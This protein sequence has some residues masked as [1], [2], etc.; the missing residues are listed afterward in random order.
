MFFGSY[1]AMVI[2]VI[3]AVT[4]IIRS[5]VS[6]ATQKKETPKQDLIFRDLIRSHD[7]AERWKIFYTPDTKRGTI[8]EQHGTALGFKFEPLTTTQQ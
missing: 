2:A 7:P 4:L 3:V 1:V 5:N 6:Y 8:R